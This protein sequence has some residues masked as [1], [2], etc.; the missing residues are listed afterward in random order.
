MMTKSQELLMLGFV[1][2]IPNQGD[3]KFELEFR[4]ISM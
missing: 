2:Y 1:A 3:A 4:K